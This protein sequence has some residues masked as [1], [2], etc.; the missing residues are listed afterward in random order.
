SSVDI[1]CRSTLASKRT[2]PSAWASAGSRIANTASVTT[3]ATALPIL[4]GIRPPPLP[5]LGAEELQALLA[6]L[7]RVEDPLRLRGAGRRLL[8]GSALLLPLAFLVR[9][10]AGTLLGP[11]GVL[12]LLRTFGLPL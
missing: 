2:S 3:R 4:F 12:A 8:R 6:G 10:G 1:A 5:I 11:G 7:E 9:R